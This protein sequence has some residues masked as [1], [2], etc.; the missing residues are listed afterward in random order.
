MRKNKYPSVPYSQL[1]Q[2]EKDRIN[3][4]KR[5]LA[6]EKKR[7]EDALVSVNIEQ[8]NIVH[9]IISLDK[10]SGGPARTNDATASTF[11][12]KSALHILF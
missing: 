12:N 2:E 3:A 4:R 6:L 9:S 5:A 7:M 8:D 10:F 1:P 11:A